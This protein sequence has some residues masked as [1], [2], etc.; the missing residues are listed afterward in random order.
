MTIPWQLA[1]RA[2]GTPQEAEL[3]GEVERARQ[4]ATAIAG[5]VTLAGSPRKP[6]IAV[7]SQLEQESSFSTEQAISGGS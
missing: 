1:P 4:Q 2:A 7:A 3:K 5:S 6:E